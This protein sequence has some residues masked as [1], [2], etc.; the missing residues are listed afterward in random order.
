[1]IKILNR[2]EIGNLFHYAHFICDC[3]FPEII[4]GIYKNK[5]II[6]EKSISQTLGNFLPIYC[7]IMNCKCIEIEQSLFDSINAKLYINKAKED[8]SNPIYFELFRNYIFNR[9]KINPSIIYPKYP[10]VILIQRGKRV[11]LIRDQTLQVNNGNY[12]NGA[13]RREINNIEKVKIFMKNKFGIHYQTLVLENISFEKQIQ[14]FNNAKIIVCA[15]GACMSNL[16]FC[17]KDTILFE[18]TCGEVWPFFDIITKNLQIIHHKIEDNNSN[19]I[20]NRIRDEN[21]S[22][23]DKEIIVEEI[24]PLLESIPNNILPNKNVVNKTLPINKKNSFFTKKSLKFPQNILYTTGI[25]YSKI[26]DVY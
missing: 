4:A 16:F 6:R 1:M 17:K 18:V 10:S 13:E 5:R 14:Y 12:T 7:R 24:N 2:R 23:S 15:H 25:N 9:F 3:L 19:V 8:L 20:I 21:I 26:Y 22:L 11:N